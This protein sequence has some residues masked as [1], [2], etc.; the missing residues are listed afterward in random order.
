[1][2]AEELLCPLISTV[3]AISSAFQYAA[4]ARVPSQSG[5]FA[6]PFGYSSRLETDRDG[7][8][9]IRNAAAFILHKASHEMQ[10]YRAQSS[11]SGSCG[12]RH[13][14]T[15][16]ANTYGGTP[17]P[18]FLARLWDDRREGSSPGKVCGEPCHS[19]CSAQANVPMRGL[20]ACYLSLGSSQG[21]FCMQVWAPRTP[22]PA[23][24]KV[25][26]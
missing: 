2:Q 18:L 21:L 14:V 6:T 3:W 13:R 9:S 11:A 22:V 12:G 24:K 8:S 25:E 5:Y 4:P 16:A 19:L 26:F 1:M 20:L 10:S 7:K 17:S 23:K 15:S